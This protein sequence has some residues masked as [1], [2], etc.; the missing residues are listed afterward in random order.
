M[1]Q[2]YYIALK[3]MDYKTLYKPTIKLYTKIS[4]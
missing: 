4:L 2:A 1:N 3:N